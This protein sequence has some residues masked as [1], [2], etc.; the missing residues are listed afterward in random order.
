M[1]KAPAMAH[2]KSAL[3]LPAQVRQGRGQARREA[4]AL[5]VIGGAL[6]A[7]AYAAFVANPWIPNPSV[8][9]PP[10]VHEHTSFIPNAA[11]VPEVDFCLALR[12]AS[13][14]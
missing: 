8:G 7:A 12:L 5:G 4:V 1:G 14:G 11:L 9:L 10:P 13:L 6:P 2:A 3:H